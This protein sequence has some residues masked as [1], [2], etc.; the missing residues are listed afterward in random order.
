MP[1]SLLSE[2]KRKILNP[3]TLKD[4][5]LR[6]VL[7]STLLPNQAG[8]EVLTYCFTLAADGVPSP[9]GHIHLRVGHSE[10]LELYQGHIGYGVNQA[11]RGRH[12]AERASRLLLPFAAE[13][14]LNPVWITCDP[15]NLP[16][17][18]T[19]ERLGAKF[20]EIVDVPSTAL[21]YRFGARRKCRYRL[22]LPIV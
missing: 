1:P 13:Q 19:C 9:V 8:V 11:W 17:R 6:V 12:F 20:V 15:D 2:V 22:D 3:G 5:E 10:N 18:R 14:G 16:S 4:R 21:A 7:T